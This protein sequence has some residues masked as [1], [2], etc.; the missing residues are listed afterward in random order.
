MIQIALQENTQ[1]CTQFVGPSFCFGTSDSR[2]MQ[3]RI[4]ATSGEQPIVAVIQIPLHE[5][6]Q[7]CMQFVGA[8]FCFGT[9]I[10]Y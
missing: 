9:S 2:I 8:S 6:R 4:T 10:T 1:H 7:N 5:N 3:S